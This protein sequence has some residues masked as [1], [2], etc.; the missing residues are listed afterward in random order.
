MNRGQIADGKASTQHQFPKG[1]KEGPINN[2]AILIYFS[3][4]ELKHCLKAMWRV[5]ALFGLQVTVYHRWKLG[6]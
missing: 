4:A 1:R 2:P 5:K 6:Q 3:I